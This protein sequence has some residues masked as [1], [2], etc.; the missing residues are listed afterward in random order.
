MSTVWFHL[1][2]PSTRLVSI[3]FMY[4]L[5][6]SLC[7]RRFCIRSPITMVALLLCLDMILLPALLLEP[8][9]IWL[10]VQCIGHLNIISFTFI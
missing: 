5:I 8:G 4:F 1:G 6:L 3:T 9:E 10:Y 7:I 2:I